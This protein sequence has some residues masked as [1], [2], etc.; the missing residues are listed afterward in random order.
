MRRHGGLHRYTLKQRIEK[1]LTTHM[2]KI[3]PDPTLNGET[4]ASV[5]EINENF[6]DR[7]YEGKPKRGSICR[8]K[9]T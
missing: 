1:T 2:S 9:Q 4:Q 6:P 7:M 3:H 8:T 5:K